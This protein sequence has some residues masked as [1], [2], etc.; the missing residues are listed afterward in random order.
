M[1]VFHQLLAII[2]YVN[3]FHV[4]Q[5]CWKN[6]KELKNQNW[7]IIG[8]LI[9]LY[10]SSLHYQLLNY[11]IF[12]L[13][14]FYKLKANNYVLYEYCLN[15]NIYWHQTLLFIFVTILFLSSLLI[16][17]DLLMNIILKSEQWVVNTQGSKFCRVPMIYLECHSWHFHK[18]FHI[19]A[20]AILNNMVN[21]NM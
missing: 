10:Q 12:T 6:E 20:K 19:K 14:N 7:L 21:W 13:C 17:M 4:R 15:E 11:N 16:Y 1:S 9:S 2:Y 3:G 18:Y 8:W 5:K